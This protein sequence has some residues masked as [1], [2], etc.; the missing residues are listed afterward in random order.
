MDAARPQGQ[1]RSRTW[2]LK[3]TQKVLSP[4]L[5]PLLLSLS[6]C[7]TSDKHFC[8]YRQGAEI[9]VCDLQANL[10][11]RPNFYPIDSSRRGRVTQHRPGCSLQNLWIERKWEG[12]LGK[13]DS[14]TVQKEQTALKGSKA[15]E[16]RWRMGWH[17]LLRTQNKQRC[18]SWRKTSL[19]EGKEPVIGPGLGPFSGVL[20]PACKSCLLNIQEFFF[21]SFFFFLIVVQV[22]LSPFSHHHFPLPHPPP[23]P[24]LNPTPLWLCPWVFYTCSFQEF[25]ELVV[26]HSLQ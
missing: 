22:Q 14:F 26:K 9:F 4:R 10:G 23:P 19:E 24:T 11:Q 15:E 25:W 17:L 7:L 21:P 18:A 13:E 20:E 3:E 2:G 16:R 6:L 12:T 5:S 1:T 8:F